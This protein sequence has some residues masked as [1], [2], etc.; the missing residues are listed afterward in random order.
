M[1]TKC[2]DPIWPDTGAAPDHPPHPQIL[3]LLAPHPLRFTL[4]I[5]LQLALANRC[6]RLGCRPQHARKQQS[7]CVPSFHHL[8]SFTSLFFSPT[9]P[10]PRTPWGAIERSEPQRVTRAWLFGIV[11]GCGKEEGEIVVAGGGGGGGICL[12]HMDGIGQIGWRDCV[13][14]SGVFFNVMKTQEP[15]YLLTGQSQLY[16]S[17]L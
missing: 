13:C 5:T 15:S 2:K 16:I 17:Q 11:R 12:L 4:R 10:F 1:L 6:S 3:P 8:L 7:Y 9:S 14:R